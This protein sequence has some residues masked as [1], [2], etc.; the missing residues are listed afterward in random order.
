[1]MV[2]FCKGYTGIASHTVL[3]VDAKTEPTATDVAKRTV[4]D[5]LIWPVIE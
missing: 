5:V 1:M 4:I 2:V 3:V